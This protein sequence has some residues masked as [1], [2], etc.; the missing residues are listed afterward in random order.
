MGEVFDSSETL[1]SKVGKLL[2]GEEK[3]ILLQIKDGVDTDKAQRVVSAA[4]SKKGV[5]LT[6][7]LIRGVARGEDKVV[8]ILRVEVKGVSDA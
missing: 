6:S 5:R 8:N 1:T 7:K 4:A 3:F 2:S